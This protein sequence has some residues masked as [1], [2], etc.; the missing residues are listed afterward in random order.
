MKH[1]IFPTTTEFSNKPKVFV[2]G[3]FES[4]HLGHRKVLARAKEIALENKY[5]Y[6]AMI[7]SQRPSDNLYSIE[8]RIMF[9]NEYKPDYIW[10]FT[11]NKENFSITHLEFEEMLLSMNV[12]TIVVGKNF[13]YG[14]NRQGNLETLKKKFEVIAFE[15]DEFSTTS[16]IQ[17]IIDSD[18]VKFKELMNHYFFYKGNVVKGLGNGKKFN[19][20]TANV[21]YPKYKI[22]VNEGI[23]YSYV[24]YDGMRMPSLTSVSNNPTLNAKKITYETYIY[25]FDKDIYGEEIYVELVEKIRDPIKFESIEKLVDQLEKDKEIGR[26]YFKI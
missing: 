4:I 9:I 5:E 21:E 7:F 14:N 22:S 2:L 18:Y 3:K 12:K 23:Y 24:I 26:E 25:D 11:P 19:M 10:E 16:V 6:G 8:E 17:S 13:M 1:I 20:P 15:I